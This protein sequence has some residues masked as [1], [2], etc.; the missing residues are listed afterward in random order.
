LNYRKI[1]N[2]FYDKAY[3]IQRASSKDKSYVVYSN[4]DRIYPFYFMDTNQKIQEWRRL[5]GRTIS[6]EEYAEICS[7][8]NGFFMTLKQ[9]SDDEERMLPENGQDNNKRGMLLSDKTE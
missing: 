4:K 1:E 8:L 3:L 5:Y 6:N 2:I 7:N 9:W